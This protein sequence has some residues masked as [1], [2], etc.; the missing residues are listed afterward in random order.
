[1]QP[2]G[3]KYDKEKQ[4]KKW[5]VRECRGTIEKKTPENMKRS[6]ARESKGKRGHARKSMG[7]QGKARE[8]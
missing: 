4:G 6:E 1:M 3:R 7:K 8:S 5:G 2:Q